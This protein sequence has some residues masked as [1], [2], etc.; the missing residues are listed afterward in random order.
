M[1]DSAI[2]QGK[3][4][5]NFW[6]LAG[7]LGI[8][9]ATSMSRDINRPFYGL[10]SWGEAHAYWNARVHLNYGLGYTKGML[11]KAVGNPPTEKPLRYLNHPQLPS[12]I[13]NVPFMAVFGQNELSLRIKKILVACVTLLLFLKILKYQSRDIYR[14][15]MLMLRLDLAI[16]FLMQFFYNAFF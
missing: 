4:Y 14:Y 7:L 3:R 1:S 2:N 9:L 15:L 16:T 12:M 13:E 11:T 6:L 10:H 8:L 5:D